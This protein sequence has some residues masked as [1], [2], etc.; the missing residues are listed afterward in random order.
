MCLV[1]LREAILT[2]TRLINKLT[3]FLGFKSLMD[4]LSTLY[5]DLHTTDNI[6][7]L[8]IGCV[9]SMPTVKA[10]GNLS[11]G[12][13]YVFV[14]YSSTEKRYKCY[15]PPSK[16]YQVSMDVTLNEQEPYFTNL[17]LQGEFNKGK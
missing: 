9:M 1:L 2:D 15:H 8:I 13:K 6:V 12:S 17:Y 7:P 14:G 16:K 5:L 4:I 10:E 11:K 3:R